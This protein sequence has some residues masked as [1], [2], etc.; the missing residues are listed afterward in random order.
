MILRSVCNRLH[1]EIRKAKLD[2]ATTFWRE[3][4]IAET[5][6]NGKSTHLNDVVKSSNKDRLFRLADRYR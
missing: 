6:L 2:R 4:F 1:C 3:I 5:T